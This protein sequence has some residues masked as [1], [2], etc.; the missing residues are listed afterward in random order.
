MGIGEFSR[1]IAASSPQVNSLAIGTRVFVYNAAGNSVE[2]VVQN[3]PL[4]NSPVAGQTRINFV[5]TWANDYSAAAGG[6]FI[7]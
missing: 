1:F 5:G 3:T 6:Y 4:I 7:L 2:K